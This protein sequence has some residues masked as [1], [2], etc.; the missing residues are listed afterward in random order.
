MI[1][2]NF[3]FKEIYLNISNDCNLRCIYCSQKKSNWLLITDTLFE[4]YLDKILKFTVNIKWLSIYGW[5]PLLYKNKLKKVIYLYLNKSNKG[6][7][8]RIIINTNWILIDKDFLIFIKKILKI[9]L[10]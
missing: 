7:F 5:E 8:H 4:E 2:N 10:I 3:E 1:K 6:L 9:I